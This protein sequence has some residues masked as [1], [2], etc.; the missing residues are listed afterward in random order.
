MSI[1][2]V[3]HFS[4]DPLPPE[5]EDQRAARR[6]S[7]ADDGSVAARRVSRKKETTRRPPPVEIAFLL[8]YGVSIETLNAAVG[9]ARGQG[10][11]PDAALLAEGLVADEDFYR[12]LAD[13]LGVDF[14]DGDIALMPDSLATA[15]LGYTQL[16]ER[17]DGAR[18][19]FSP[20]GT[21]I[22]RLMTV[23][24]AAKGRPLFAVTRRARFAQ[25]LRAAYPQSAVVAASHSAEHVDESLC[26]RRSLR[27]WPLAWASAA[28]FAVIACLFAP[29]EFL[30]LGAAFAFAA[31]FLSSVVLRLA[32]C[33]AS[34]ER[35]AEE[36]RIEDARLPVYTVVIALYKE[37]AVAPQLARAI[38][39]MAQM[40]QAS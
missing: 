1:V 29:V 9:L 15:S 28:L 24:R 20:C 38:D 34:S 5:S 26:V 4:R 37:A 36:P 7:L 3:D 6:R 14:L 31:A 25:A 13:H 22:F 35:Q 33:A 17:R 16:R 12:A 11:S 8:N 32:A 19:L 2:S 23:A 30:R 27:R 18:W 10:V 39:R 21:Q 40:P